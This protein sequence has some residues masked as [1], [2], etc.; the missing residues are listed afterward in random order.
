MCST[1]SQP[2]RSRKL[3]GFTMIELL[4]VISITSVLVSLLLP[5]V[6]SARE[7]ARRLSCSSKLRQIGLA[8]HNYESTHEVFPP[9]LQVQNFTGSRPFSKAF[10]WSIELLP[11][12]EQQSLYDQFD[13]RLDAQIHH[14]E[15]TKMRLPI[16]ECPSDPNA[17]V[18][19]WTRPTNPVWG[20]Y[21]AGHWGTTNYL[22]VSGTNGWLSFTQP[23]DCR[24][25]VNRFDGKGLHDGMFFGNSAVRFADVVDGTSNTLF[26][27]ERGVVPEHGKW[28]GSGVDA[29]CPAGIADV[30]LPGVVE[31]LDPSGGIRLPKGRGSDRGFWWSWHP[32]GTHFL[33]VDGGVRFQ[34]FNVDRKVLRDM[35]SRAEGASE[36]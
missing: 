15:Q 34:S 29:F 18:V 17:G 1:I 23:L 13:M 31:G 2:L 30:L 24:S 11:Y 5:A 36:F 32:G 14:R 3:V 7:G 28:G 4:V 27:G 16:Y 9:G 21:H 12:L 6:Q 33:F 10:G 19:L 20:D 35:S 26:V 22:G 8:L 25:F